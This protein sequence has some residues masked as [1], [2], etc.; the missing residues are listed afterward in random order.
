M[1]IQVK[2]LYNNSRLPVSN[3][4]GS[5]DIFSAEDKIIKPGESALIN[6]G[7]IMYIPLG[8]CGLIQSTE[9][10][11]SMCVETKDFAT[12]H[13]SAASTTK[14]NEFS[15]YLRNFGVSAA[16]IAAGDVVCRLIIINIRILD[17]KKVTIIEEDIETDKGCE[18]IE[19][20]SKWFKKQYVTDSGAVSAKYFTGYMI[21]KIALFKETNEYISSINKQAV[22]ANYIWE[23]LSKSIKTKIMADFINKI[24]IPPKTI[25]KQHKNDPE[26]SSSDEYL[27]DL[28]LIDDLESN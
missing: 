28:D 14:L 25:T 19:G 15:V 23:I 13:Y 12:I 22:E 26:T 27:S 3:N 6:T 2:L 16:T 9:L 18:T 10:L 5:Y 20:V 8:F 4:D 1:S 24:E 7:I 17:V 11:M 21:N